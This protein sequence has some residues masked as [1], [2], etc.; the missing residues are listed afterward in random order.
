MKDH[1]IKRVVF[2]TAGLTSLP[3]YGQALRLLEAAAHC[4][5]THFDTAPLYGKGYAEW[6]LG[7]HLAR[8]RSNA[9]VTSKFGLGYTGSIRIHPF[10][11]MPLNKL[12]KQ[13]GGKGGIEVP[14]TDVSR[15]PSYREISLDQVRASLQATLDRIG[16]KRVDVYLLHEGLPSFLDSQALSYLLRKRKEGV[17]G[18]LGVGTHSEA[19]SHS[20]AE[21]FSSFDVLQYDA[22]PHFTGLKDRFPE[23]RHYL[24][25]CFRTNL[26][27]SMNPHSNDS[28]L[29]QWSDK[30]P[31]GKVLFF[32]RRVQ[33]INKNT[34]AFIAV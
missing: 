23:K 34:E 10:I 15:I 14:N 2:G 25:G 27:P 20:T 3:S 8:T 21:D 12:R 11:A 16:R 33:T 28:A 4:G 31:D 5:I 19:L 29:R 6:I 32:S 26:P 30:N 7:R 13:I 1:D 18:L 9:M 22:G 24:Y 17:I